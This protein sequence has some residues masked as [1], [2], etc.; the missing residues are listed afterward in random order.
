MSNPN[1][2]GGVAVRIQQL[3]VLLVLLAVMLAVTHLSSGM[4]GAFGTLT[5][6]GFLLLGGTLASELLEPLKVPHLTAYIVAGAVAGPY[7]LHLLDHETVERLSSVNTLAIALIALAGGAELRLEQLQKS[8]RTLLVASG[9]Q[10]F[11]L[12]SS[13][14]TVFVLVRP[15]LPFTAGLPLAEVCGL[16]LMWG[17]LAITRSPS[18][19]LGIMAQTRA[20]GP[21]MDFTLAFVM[22][23]DVM[24]IVVLAV[25]MTLTKP[26]FEPG[27]TLSMAAFAH[28]GH[29]ILGSISLGTTLGL[30]LSVYLRFVDRQLLPVLL[31][32]GLGF[33]EVVRYLNFEPLLTFLV[34][35][36]IVQNLS[37]QG[38]KFLHALEGAGSVV[39]VI[40][41]A[42][43]GAHLQLPL[44]KTLWPV[45]LILCG[46]RAFLT[47]VG[48]R[49]STRIT[50]DPPVLR[51][52]GWSGLVSQ[53]GIALGIGA[54]MERALPVYG[55][56]VRAL[57]IATVAI[58]EV[59][60]PIFFKLVLDRL[61]ESAPEAEAE[62]A[63][64]EPTSNDGQ[65][66]HT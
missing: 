65:A 6:I 53:A 44:L 39:Y 33:T 64:P 30:V 9:M 34:A 18:A 32:L 29:E 40:F 36:F 19:T 50:K 11:F 63:A 37:K 42:G 49:L 22:S 66:A 25:V 15:L 7:A 54:M 27:A 8:L 21:V 5:A 26:L 62:P 48:H 28:L 57:V 43:A 12:L 51:R 45:A 38:D 16:G 52:W 55:T 31:L 20:K 60:G 41:F 1:A 3:L 4:E 14:A 13:M 58:N 23:S 10:T 35:G 46:S 61:G 24:V 59:V 2:R 47:M 17:V 56:S